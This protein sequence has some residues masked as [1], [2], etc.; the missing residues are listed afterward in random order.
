MSLPPVNAEKKKRWVS[1]P[2]VPLPDD[3]RKI[4]SP[5]PYTV[6]TRAGSLDL[7]FLSAYH[8]YL[9]QY[10]TTQSGV[11]P[12]PTTSPNDISGSLPSF[13]L[14]LQACEL[15]RQLSRVVE[16]DRIFTLY[17]QH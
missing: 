2:T 5:V 14:L 13:P 15:S 17:L 10:L 11:L 9:D 6:F 12:P 4:T 16:E 1:L 3:A 7:P 8:A